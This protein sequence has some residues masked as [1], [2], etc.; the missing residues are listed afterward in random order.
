M[1]VHVTRTMNRNFASLQAQVDSPLESKSRSEIEEKRRISSISC[2]PSSRG[3]IRLRAFDRVLPETRKILNSPKA[4]AIHAELRHRD[5]CPRK[6]GGRAHQD[7]ARNGERRAEITDAWKIKSR[8]TPIGRAI[9]FR[10]LHKFPAFA[11][12]VGARVVRLSCEGVAYGRTGENA[13]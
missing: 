4:K 9:T 7:S 8:V 11:K 5:K 3:A 2:A 13:R 6:P 10:L 12:G 1:S